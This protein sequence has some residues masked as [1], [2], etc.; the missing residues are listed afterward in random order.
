MRSFDSVGTSQG[1]HLTADCCGVD[2]SRGVT[3]WSGISRRRY[4][5]ELKAIAA[6]EAITPNCCG[7]RDKEYFALVKAERARRLAHKLLEAM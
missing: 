6:G 7:M 5:A 4:H 1:T 2:H 3:V